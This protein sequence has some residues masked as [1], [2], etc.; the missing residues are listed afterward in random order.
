MK[1]SAHSE[2]EMVNAVHKLERGIKAETVACNHGICKATLYNWKSK[3]NGMD[4]SQIRRL[5]E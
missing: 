2:N 5:K 4:V 3:S 1:K